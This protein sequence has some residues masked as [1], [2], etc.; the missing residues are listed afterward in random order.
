MN[1]KTL[2]ALAAGS[3]A[4]AV[5]AVGSAAMAYVTTPRNIN[6]QRYLM[7]ASD[8]GSGG[9]AIAPAMDAAISPDGTK[10]AYMSYSQSSPTGFDGSIA[11]LAS[12]AT[13][14]IGTACAGTPIWAPNSLLLACQTQSVAANDT[15]TGNG[16]GLVAVPATLT[17]GATLPVS[18]WIAPRG[19]YVDYSVAFSPDSAS[20]AFAWR[21]YSSRAITTL[22]TAPVANSAARTKVLARAAGPVWGAPG[23]V[24]AQQTNVREKVGPSVMRTVHSELWLVQPNGTGA[25]RITNYKAKGLT[26]GPFAVAW[27]PAGNMLV[28][29][30]GGQDQEDLGTITLA[31][32]KVRILRKGVLADPVA[33]SADGQRILFSSGMEGGPRTIQVIGV[34]G[35]GLRTLVRQAG[36]PTVTAGWNG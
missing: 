3:A 10:V 4:L 28:G 32:G 35:R 2:I 13:V 33:I 30:V 24:A 1:R 9:R 15:V 7:V 12:G 26:T 14:S 23:I 16:L 17:N 21:T 36:N 22:Y 6:T 8:D 5:P 31:T 20:I 19:N 29:G 25:R 27:A 34:N 18:D 11:D